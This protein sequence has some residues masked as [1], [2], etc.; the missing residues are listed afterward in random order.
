MF[1]LGSL[2][3]TRAT[4]LVGGTTLA[5]Y[6]ASLL[7]LVPWP[8]QLR[9]TSVLMMVLGGLFFLVAILLS[10]YRERLLQIPG[11]IK[12]GQGIYQVLKWR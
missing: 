1:G 9:D 10:A 5:L 12:S 3:Q 7:F 11:K 8:D 6:V 2:L 4:T